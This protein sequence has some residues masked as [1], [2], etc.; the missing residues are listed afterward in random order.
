MRYFLLLF[1]FCAFSTT[2]FAQ[3]SDTT[4]SLGRYGNWAV[5][6][7]MENGKK[8]CFMATAPSITSV[9]R[10]DNFLMIV[11]RP[12]EKSFDVVTLMLGADFHKESIPT[13]GVDNNKV[14]S[15]K[16]AKN[17]AFI[18]DVALEQDM[19]QQMIKG[20]V[21]RTQAKSAR[22]TILKETFSL[23]GFSKAYDALNRSCPH[24][25]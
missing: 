24:R 9:K 10:D 25:K 1:I 16:T 15:M 7:A 5:Y 17:A 2:V 3:E 21:A 20:G 12:A 13:L 14:T 8:M 19:I 23:K 6:S 18:E 4:T 22:G 11:H